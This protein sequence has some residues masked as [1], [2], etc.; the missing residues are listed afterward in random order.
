M[1]NTK[2]RFTEQDSI[3]LGKLPQPEVNAYGKRLAQIT[4]RVQI[5]EDTYSADID[6]IREDGA[7]LFEELKIRL[8]AFRETG[9]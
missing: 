8:A 3:D 4:M 7:I 9:C 1:T 6:E 2:S 5:V